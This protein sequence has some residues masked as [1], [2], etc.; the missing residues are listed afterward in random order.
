MNN[1]IEPIVGSWYQD[2]INGR[3]FQVVALDEDEAQ[4]ELQHS[5]GDIEELTLEEWHS[6]DVE[7]AEAPDDWIGPLDD[8]ELDNLDFASTR[9]EGESRGLAQSRRSE[10]LQT[11]ENP[12]DA[13]IFEGRPEDEAGAPDI[14]EGSVRQAR[15]Q[16]RKTPHDFE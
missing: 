13:G 2:L 5:D 10:A 1:E 12:E 6:M 3:V 9:S 7:S 14:V 11:D 15:D 8:A 16:L 4:V